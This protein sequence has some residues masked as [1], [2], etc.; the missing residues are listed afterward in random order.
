MSP[1]TIGNVLIIAGAHAFPP[2][3]VRVS[4]AI[5]ADVAVA[6]PVLYTCTLQSRAA[7]VPVCEIN[8]P[9]NAGDP[10]DMTE[11]LAEALAA[12]VE[13]AALAPIG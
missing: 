7:V 13:A 1:S 2:D 9:V 11:Q 8:D 12:L 5:C 10:E 4:P 3:C 6:V